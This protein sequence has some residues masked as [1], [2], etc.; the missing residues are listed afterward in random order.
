MYEI[1]KQRLIKKH[2]ALMVLSFV[3]FMALCILSGYAP[4][5][6]GIKEGDP[7]KQI[8]LEDIS[9]TKVDVAGFFGNA[10]V[11]LVFWKLTGKEYLDYSLD[12]LIFLRDF[13]EQYHEKTGLKIF[14]IYTPEEDK[15]IPGFEINAVQNLIK[16]NRITFPILIDRGFKMYKEYGVIALPSTIMID[17]TGKVKFIYPGFP[18]SAQSIFAEQIMDLIGLSKIAREDKGIKTKRLDTGSNR[19]YQYALQMYKRGLLEQAISPLKKSMDVEPDYTWS[20]NLMGIILSKR[21]SFEGSAEKFKYAMKLDKDNVAAYFNYGLLLFENEKYDDAEQY[22]KTS[23]TL[24][25]ALA[26]THYVL[27][28]LYKKTNRRGEALNELKTALM[29]FEKKKAPP[30]YET[31]TFYRISILYALSDLYTRQGDDKKAFG[32]LQ[33]AVQIAL[34]IDDKPEH[35][36]RIEELMMYE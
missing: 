21:G 32:L 4:A 2:L 26:E 27:G 34:G 5:L 25:N 35:F 14:G 30:I 16:I 22:L 10:P 11:I 29:L 23:I 1:T 12:E 20:H 13:H 7:P 9:G 28:L 17:K 3:F 36:R 33:Q 24:N 6:I 18:I 31:P 19:L 15:D 8:I